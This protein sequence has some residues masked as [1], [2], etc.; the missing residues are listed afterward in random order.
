MNNDLYTFFWSGM[1]SQWYASPFKVD[2]IQ[3]NCAEQ[4]MMH[5]KALMFEDY[6][7]AELIMNTPNP[8]IQK[9]LGRQV[10]NFN[11]DSWNA[12]AKTVVYIA[13][14][15]KFTH[16]PTLLEALLATGD[17]LLVEASPYDTIWGIGMGEVEARKST[18]EQWRGTN[19]LGEVLTAVRDDIRS[20]TV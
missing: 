16:S 19:W 7:T 14:I 5:S 4:F 15:A 18:K 10:K 2:G 9:Q 11:A 17:T 12:V 3:Y 1:F 20:D 13:N 8:K 6:E